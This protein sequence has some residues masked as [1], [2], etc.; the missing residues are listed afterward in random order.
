M[1]TG[2]PAGLDHT[3]QEVNPAL[4]SLLIRLTGMMVSPWHH[5][6]TEKEKWVGLAHVRRHEWAATRGSLLE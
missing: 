3:K 2:W 6:V 1:G 4:R 5:R